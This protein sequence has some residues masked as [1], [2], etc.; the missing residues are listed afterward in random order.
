MNL[1]R[2]FII[3]FFISPFFIFAD[4]LSIP[5]FDE[6][7]ILDYKVGVRPYRK[8]GVRLEAEWYNEKLIIHNYGHGGAG[9]TLSW[10]SAQEVLNILKQEIVSNVKL[11]KEK[12]IAIIGGGIIGFCAADIL[13]E[14]GYQVKIYAEKFH[15][16]TTADVAAGF[17]GAFSVAIPTELDKKEQFNRILEQSEKKLQELYECKDSTIQG[18]SYTDFYIFNTKDET[19]TVCFGNRMTRLC[20]KKKQLTMKGPLYF[21]SIFQK[22]Q[23][24]GA[25]IIVKKFDTISDILALPESIVINCTGIG[26]KKLFNDTDLIGIKGHVVHIKKDNFDVLIGDNDERSSFFIMPWED[27]LVLGSRLTQEY[28]D[29]SEELNFNKCYEIL[30]FARNFFNINKE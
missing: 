16:D 5:C 3:S 14:H 6:T 1:N 9:L 25:L 19:D 15:P 8:T 12:T 4:H 17:F 29:D 7:H 27:R 26:S 22:V 11:D 30:S 10:G 28:D 13:L 23:R 20:R 2:I 18:V 21:K 24:E